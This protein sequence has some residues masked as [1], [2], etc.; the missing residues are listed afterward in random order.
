MLTS[1]EEIKTGFRYVHSKLF[2]IILDFL[3]ELFC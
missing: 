3:F 2:M 1:I